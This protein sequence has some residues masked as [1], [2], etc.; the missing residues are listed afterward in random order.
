M[1]PGFWIRLSKFALLAAN[2]FLLFLVLI[3][4]LNTWFWYQDNLASNSKSKLESFEIRILENQKSTFGRRYLVGSQI[5][6]LLLDTTQNYR[7]GFKYTISADLEKYGLEGKNS[8]TEM[9][10]KKNREGIL[11]NAQDDK[12]QVHDNKTQQKNNAS[13]FEENDSESQDDKQ[14]NEKVDFSSYYLSVGVVGRLSK[15]KVLKNE[16]TCDWQCQVLDQISK[17]RFQFK[18]A[19]DQLICKK[20]DFINKFFGNSCDQ[21]L[22]WT[23]GLVL[24]QGDLFSSQTKADLKKIGITH[25]VVIS[26][27]QVGLLFAF[28]DFVLLKLRILRRWRVV[29][30]WFGIGFLILIAGLQAPVLRSSLSVFLGSLALVWFGRG[31]NAYRVLLYSALILLW[32]FPNYIVSYSF[33]LSFAATFGLILFSPKN[34]Q[35]VEVEFFQNF[36]SLVLSCLGTFLFTLPLI[37]NL[38]GN[39][40]PFGVIVNLLLIPIIPVLT[41]LN[42]LGLIPFVGEL[43]GLVFITLQNW[44]VILVKDLAQLSVQIPL[45]HF[46]L[47]EIGLYWIVLSI[48]TLLIKVK[49]SSLV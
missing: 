46:E 40:S 45:K 48:M 8:L 42:I 3:T 19:Y 33:W 41:L 20:L 39:I 36:K 37:V 5:G 24:G 14:S 30:C 44:L 9:E 21:I 27:F 35:I 15:D 32:I 6:N 18:L 1:S 43:F 25:L 2:W 4:G 13:N 49:I 38:S 26:G 23:S 16:S 29:L 7:I 12:S 47:W 11:H 31:V 22:A 17:L 10:S 34:V 28:V